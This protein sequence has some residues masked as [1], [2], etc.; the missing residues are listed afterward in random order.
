MLLFSNSPSSHLIELYWQL[1]N[2][3]R[4]CIW[5]PC[6]YAVLKRTNSHTLHWY[7]R[8]VSFHELRT[9]QDF[10]KISK[11]KLIRSSNIIRF[12]SEIYCHQKSFNQCYFQPEDLFT[13]FSLNDESALVNIEHIC[14]LYT[15]AHSISCM[16]RTYASHSIAERCQRVECSTYEH[17]R[18]WNANC[19]LWDIIHLGFV[20]WIWFIH[21]T[22]SSLDC[23]TID[24][25]SQIVWERSRKKWVEIKK[26]SIKLLN[27]REEKK[28]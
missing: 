20:S 25:N 21:E 28:K 23:R 3:I 15:S 7:S 2:K 22:V 8:S 11:T 1:N 14:T 19:R 9:S 4:W 27:S 13:F 24:N 5:L 16:L 12:S 18:L 17:I 10:I 26:N 6:L